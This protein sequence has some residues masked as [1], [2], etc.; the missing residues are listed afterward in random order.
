MRKELILV[1]A[2]IGESNASSSQMVDLKRL[3]LSCIV[4]GIARLGH[5]FGLSLALV[6]GA[7]YSS[8]LAYIFVSILL[9]KICPFVASLAQVRVSSKWVLATSNIIS[10]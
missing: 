9:S 4:V 1:T 2:A 7:Q 6:V 5:F 3:Y 10:R 8:T